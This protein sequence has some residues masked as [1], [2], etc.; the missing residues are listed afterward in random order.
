MMLSTLQEIEGTYRQYCTSK[1]EFSCA[2]LKLELE[3]NLGLKLK[4][5]TTSTGGWWVDEWTKM[6][7]M[8]ISTQ[9]EVVVTGWGS[10]Q[11]VSF[12]SSC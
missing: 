6:K 12:F 7:L 8:L 4:L 9:V 11:E 2:K 5:A 10:D 3:L 1:L